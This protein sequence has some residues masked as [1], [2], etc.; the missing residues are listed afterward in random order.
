MVG[1]VTPR[2]SLLMNMV[3]VLDRSANSVCVKPRASSS[4]RR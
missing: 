2:S 3:F 1:V 4:S